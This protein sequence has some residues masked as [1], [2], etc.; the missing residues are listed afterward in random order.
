MRVT[1]IGAAKRSSAELR[2]RCNQQRDE[3]QEQPNAGN[4]TSSTGE[5][6]RSSAVVVA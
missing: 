6:C 2:Y 3:Y 5:R 1:E 4:D